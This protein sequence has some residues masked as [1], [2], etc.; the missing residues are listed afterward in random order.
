LKSLGVSVIY[1]NPV[2]WAA[3]NHKYDATDYKHLDPMFG[4]PV[5][6]KPNDPTSGLDYAKT[7][8]ASDRVFSKFAKEAKKRGIQLIVDG[9]FNHLGDDSIYFDRYEKYPE[10]GAY[11]YWS[12]VWNK[13]NDEGK[14]QEQAEQEV[15]A[16]FTG[17]GYKYPED[18]DF[19]TWFTVKNEKVIEADGKSWHYKY[20]GW[21][22]FDSLPAVDAKEPQAGDTQA[23]PG[24][25]EW[26]VPGYRDNVIG[27]DLTGK[28]DSEQ[29]Q[30]MQDANSQRWEWL[31]ARGWRLD[32]APDVSAGTWQQFRKAVKSTAGLKD[33]NNNAIDD[34][35]ILGEEWG[36][37]TRFLLGDQFDSVMN[38]RF[39]GALQDFIISGDAQ[40][41]HTA[42]E[43]IREDYPQEA[44]QV[45]LNLVDSHDTTR[46]ITKYDH[47]EWEEEHLAIAP[48][49]SDAALK[50]QELTAIFQMSYPGA[51]TI[52]Y[53]DEVGLTGTKDPDSRRTFPWERIVEG[54]KDQFSGAGRYA[55][56]FNV[57]Q[58]AANVR[59]ANEVFRTGDLRSAYA[60]ADVI[61]Y[62]RKNSTQAGLAVIN[63]SNEAKTFDAQVAGFLPDGITLKDQLFGKF[64][65]K[66]EGGKITI[67]VPAKS[68]LMMVS[69][70]KLSQ[71]APVTNLKAT[72]G[73]QQV[74][75]TWAP[76]PTATGYN[77]YRAPIEGG[78]V[79][80]VGTA[81][82]TIFTDTNV[83]NGTKYY[84]AVSAIQGTSESVMS[85]MA[86]ATPSYA[87]KS[88]AITKTAEDMTVGVGKSTSEIAV[89]ID[90]PGL[91]DDPAL[92]G[93][94]ATH[95]TARLAYYTAGGDKAAAFDT[96]LRYQSDTADGKKVYTATFEPYLAGA[97][98]YFANVTTNNGETWTASDEAVVKVIADAN[99]TT[100]P[101]A[102]TLND[103]EQ[104]SNRAAL[105]WSVTGGDIAGLEVYRKSEGTGYQRIATL[106]KDATEY[107]D[108]TV[109]NDTS[110][111]YLVAAFDQAYN[112]AFS[113]E[114]AVTPKLVMVDVT[115][116]LHLPDYTPTSDDIYIAG[117]FNGW[118][119]SGGKLQV[120]SGATTRDTLEYSFK[121]MAGKSIQYKYT[122]GSWS[123]EAFTSHKRVANDRE[124]F[125]NWAYS[126]TDTNMNL[127]IQNQG[128]N[129]MIVDDYVL[130]WVDMPMILT[131]PR[132]SYGD[133]VAYT[134]SDDTFTLKG[135]V[136]FGVAFTINGQPLPQGAMDAYGNVYAEK[137]PLQPGMNTFTLHIEP[138]EATLN[139]PWYTDKGRKSQATKTITLKINKN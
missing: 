24:Q 36:V 121:M 15:R 107:V 2:A 88:V 20:D 27:H 129:K 7:K 66:V 115:L 63:R 23:L 18:F 21:W 131:M 78:A 116:R 67:T 118:N 44:W 12:K 102:P 105:K 79:E 109:S 8:V 29:Q 122:R 75:L 54:K 3:S 70:E 77:V 125:G 73:S 45:M 101:A 43:S 13:V 48:D 100:E 22:G 92:K 1:F 58:Q 133:D 128:G 94:E 110:Y 9:V 59:N 82:S 117:D 98:S 83:I 85:D 19:T 32:V 28:S 137:L 96:K 72:A 25:H 11:E 90:A 42:L 93:K 37:A 56:I 30:L 81:T 49:A 61:A 57:Y 4:E 130:R 74:T 60:D 5:Y 16:L 119:A 108:F 26:N 41:F 52:Y 138:T 38:Y 132:I 114:K 87:I 17:Q 139:Q 120:P 136:P 39:R 55:E 124:D 134:T 126:S 65:G 33:A 50:D 51:P 112:R 64:S 34:P 86:A 62:A 35:I 6:N 113:E 14:T 95:L 80:K 76:T 40:K 127:T 71:I 69:A 53:G 99:D 31:G 89:T 68:G 103:I 97:F 106:A 10:I 47:P 91:T 104:E 135:N 46:S 84:Y 123:T 111:S